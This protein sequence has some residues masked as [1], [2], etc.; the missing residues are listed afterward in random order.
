MKKTLLIVLAIF[1]LTLTNFAQK[2]FVGTIKYSVE[3]EEENMDAQQK[4]IIPTEYI[5]TTD[6]VKIRID[7]IA[8]MYTMTQ[9]YD[10]KKG[11]MWFMIDAIVQKV[12]SEQTKED[13]IADKAEIKAILDSLKK[14]D[15]EIIYIDES[16]TIAGFKCKKAEAAVLDKE[17]YVF[18]YTE[19][20]FFIPELKEYALKLF[21]GGKNLKGLPLEYVVTD[22]EGSM[23]VTAKEVIAKKPKSSLLF[24]DDDYEVMPWKDFKKAMG[25]GMADE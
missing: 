10:S 4:A 11:S 22:E 24:V 17:N 7:R 18:Y 6:G 12:A 15:P 14:A 5:I 1:A 16:K 25:G 13:I 21:D 9:L 23:K 8:P 20:L 2:Q 3:V 19:E